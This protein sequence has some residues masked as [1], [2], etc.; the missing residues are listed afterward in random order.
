MAVRFPDPLTGVDTAWR[1][2]ISSF[3]REE[4]IGFMIDSAMH[5]LRGDG[6]LVVCSHSTIYVGVSYV[7]PK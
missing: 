7:V 4:E 3:G 2:D 1:L 5:L 6:R